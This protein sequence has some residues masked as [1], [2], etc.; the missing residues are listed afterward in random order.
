M[1]QEIPA[2]RFSGQAPRDICESSEL[3]L[4]FK[5]DVRRGWHLRA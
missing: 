4:V 1:A 5:S 3:L 2:Q